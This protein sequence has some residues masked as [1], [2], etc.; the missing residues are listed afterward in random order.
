MNEPNWEQLSNLCPPPR[1]RHVRKRRRFDR[2]RGE[3]QVFLGDLLAP[4][5]TLKLNVFDICRVLRPAALVLDAHVA[6]SKA[7]GGG[8][9]A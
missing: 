6:A 1:R 7:P 8:P 3:E 2:H 9:P 4:S 5:W